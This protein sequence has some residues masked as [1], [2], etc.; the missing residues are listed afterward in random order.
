MPVKLR[1]R[2]A[3][4]LRYKPFTSRASACSNGVSMKI[5]KNSPG[6]IIWRTISRSARNGE[7]KALITIR[8]A[9]VMRRATSPTRL[10]FSMRSASVNPKS[11]FKPWR[12]LSPSSMKVWRFMRYSF[13]STKLAMVDL[14]APDR[15]VNHNH[16]GLLILERHALLARHID[17]LP[18]DVLRA[19]QGEM[20]HAGSHGGVAQLVDEDEAA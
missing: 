20:Q 11:R 19:A 1:S 14:P 3:R 9:S 18:V 13:L 15:P 8:P 6:A 16:A 17:C 5:S 4:A 10:M 2:P 12:T 7:M